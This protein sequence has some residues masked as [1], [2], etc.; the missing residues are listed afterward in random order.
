MKTNELIHDRKQA[1]ETLNRL[2]DKLS[3]IKK[4]SRS[5]NTIEAYQ[6]DFRHFGQW[7]ERNGFNM[8]PA[9]PEAVALYLADIKDEYKMSTLERRVSSISVIHKQSGVNNPTDVEDIKDILKGLRREK[10]TSQKEA[11]PLLASHLKRI[12]QTLTDCPID[13]RDRALLLVGFCSGQRRESLSKLSLERLSFTDEGLIATLL[14]TKTDQEGS[15]RKIGVAYG[16]NPDTCP[17]RSLKKWIDLASITGGHV[18]RSIDRHGN[19]KDNVISGRTI[20]RIIKKRVKQ[21]G[22][23]PDEFSGHSL[24]AGLVTQAAMNGVST[25]SIMDQTGHKSERIVR[26]YYRNATLFKNNASASLG[27]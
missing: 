6:S 8:L 7:C 2:E 5:T 19:I 14:Q 15:G 3:E 1:I 18:F 27:L 17:V 25:L 10:T 20:S 26:K 13:V 23:D 11:T 16:S 9:S 21:I 4:N 24:R 22:L 12:C